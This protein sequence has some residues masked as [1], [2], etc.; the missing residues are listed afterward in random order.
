M[1][2][3]EKQRDLQQV[4]MNKE[5]EK[6]IAILIL[7]LLIGRWRISDFAKLMLK[8]NPQIDDWIVWEAW[9]S[10]C[11]SKERIVILHLIL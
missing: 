6:M 5:A 3:H 2:R 11:S 4:N 8:Q 10:S 1:P 7:I 9:L